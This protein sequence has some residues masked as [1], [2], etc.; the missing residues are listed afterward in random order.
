M[1]E[2]RQKGILQIVHTI[3]MLL[4]NPQQMPQMQKQMENPIKSKNTPM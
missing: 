4:M 3:L 1:H 2:Q